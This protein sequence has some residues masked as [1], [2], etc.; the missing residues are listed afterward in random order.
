LLSDTS[1]FLIEIVIGVP[2]L[3]QFALAII[4]GLAVMHNLPELGGTTK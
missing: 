2:V 3:V 1:L 4:R